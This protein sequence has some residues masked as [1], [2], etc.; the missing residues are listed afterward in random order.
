[1]TAIE[2]EIQTGEF[3]V[4]TYKANNPASFAQV[5]KL[6]SLCKSKVS[7]SQL[8]KCLEADEANELIDLAKAGHKFTLVN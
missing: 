6:M 5:K 7:V 3:E 4:S 8:C 2:K 1:M